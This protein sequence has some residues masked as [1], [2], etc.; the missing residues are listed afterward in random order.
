MLY[1]CTSERFF[2]SLSGN[3][4]V[5]YMVILSG[6]TAKALQKDMICMAL[7]SVKL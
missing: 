1:K 5:D 4:S 2:V 3:E 7:Y 6:N